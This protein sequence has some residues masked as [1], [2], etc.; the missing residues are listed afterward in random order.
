MIPLEIEV[1]FHLTE[2]EVM[3]NRIL[4][5]GSTSLGR[6][7]ERNIRFEDEAGFI[8]KK[9]SLLRLR[10]DDKA[11]L[12]MKSEP[13][14]TETDGQ[15][16]VFRELEVT[17]SDFDTMKQILEALGYH[18]AQVYE[19]NRETFQIGASHLCLDQM[20]YGDFLEIEG[21]KSEIRGLADQLQLD[22]ERRILMNYLGIYQHIRAQYRLPFS[23]VTFDNFEAVKEDLTECIRFFETDR[24]AS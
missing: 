12:T 1:K 14:H 21:P 6:N 13:D 2:I 16:K 9:R 24:G 18:A 10:Q 3:R 19:K 23:D 20:P 5:L 7:F 4:E 11:R 22:W 17:L 8:N 15:Y